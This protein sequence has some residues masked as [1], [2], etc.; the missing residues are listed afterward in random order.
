MELAE[1]G[2]SIY[3]LMIGRNVPELYELLRIYDNKND[4]KYHTSQNTK[5]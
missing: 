4:K 2:S 5:N 1:C 3:D